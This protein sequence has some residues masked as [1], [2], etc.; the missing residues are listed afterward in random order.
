MRPLRFPVSTPSSNQDHRSGTE[1]FGYLCRPGQN[2]SPQ[3]GVVLCNPFGQEAVRSHRMYRVLAERL[4]KAGIACLR[5]DYL[6]TGD[7]DGEDEDLTLDSCIENTLRADQELRAQVGCTHVSW[8]GLRFGATVAALASKH[9]Q[10]RPDRLFLWDLVEDGGLWMEQLQRDHAATLR[11][12]ELKRPGGHRTKLSASPI[13][14]EQD[15]EVALNALAAGLAFESHGYWVNAKLHQDLQAIKLERYDAVRCS[16]LI[17]LAA[18][19]DQRQ[20]LSKLE[21]ARHIMSYDMA[22]V[23][24]SQWN[25]DEAISAAIVPHDVVSLVLAEMAGGGQ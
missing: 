2:P 19:A 15:R 21:H 1:L 7:S 22:Q 18:G 24:P 5:F 11:E 13:T 20:R 12:L 23:E 14:T 17:V 16:R 9:A 10:H 8:L 3:Q 6:G 25:S 4:A